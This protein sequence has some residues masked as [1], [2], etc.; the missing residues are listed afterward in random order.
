MFR[1][2]IK[3]IIITIIASAF[4]ILQG[5]SLPYSIFYA[6]IFIMLLSAIFFVIERKSLSLKVEFNKR[7]F[8]VGDKC[9][10]TQSIRNSSI[11]PIPPVLVKN[12]GLE[13]LDPEYQAQCIGVGVDESKWMKKSVK[14]R[15]RGYYDLGVATLTFH[16][17]FYVY[18]GK[19]LVTDNAKISVYPKLYNL[20]AFTNYGA[21]IFQNTVISKTGIN[22]AYS[23]SEV[24]KYQQGDSIKK[25]HWKVSAKHG[26]LFVKKSDKIL[27]EEGNVFIDM[28]CENYKADSSGE[29]EEKLISYAMSIINHLLGKNIQCRVFLN[30][31]ANESLTIENKNDFKLILHRIITKDS[32]GDTSFNNTIASNIGKIPTGSW[33]GLVCMNIDEAFTNYIMNLVDIGYKVNVFYCTSKMI[34][35]SNLDI[36]K[37]Y[38]ICCYSFEE[39]CMI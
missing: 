13:Q 35:K 29:L 12:Q 14:L 1:M 30:A 23:S 7:S 22:D 38:G 37:A 17:W 11:L 27:G 28:N 32:D 2:D 36:L 15:R 3:F 34:D 26:E 4:A 39:L 19:K 20:K 6:L 33:V 16:D 10:V 31:K 18:K 9:E 5:G 24:N 8:N 21:N 25:I